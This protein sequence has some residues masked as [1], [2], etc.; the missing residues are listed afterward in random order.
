MDYV[1]GR[2]CYDEETDTIIDM[3][4]QPGDDDYDE[5]SGDYDDDCNLIGYDD[6]GNEIIR[7]YISATGPPRQPKQ[8]IYQ[9]RLFTRKPWYSTT[10]LAG[11]S[12]F[13]HRH[14]PGPQ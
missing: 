2:H 1:T 6:D 14:L 8:P 7:A 5:Y 13:I 3:G 4:P 11:T 9:P 10:P 12:W